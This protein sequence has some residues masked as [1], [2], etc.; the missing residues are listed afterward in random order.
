MQETKIVITHFAS[1]T[2][3]LPSIFEYK[4]EAAAALH[5]QRCALSGLSQWEEPCSTQVTRQQ[6]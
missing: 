1:P 4:N 6:I 2:A 3:T 5:A